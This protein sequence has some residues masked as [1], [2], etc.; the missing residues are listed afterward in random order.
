MASS[1]SCWS[2]P[3]HLTAPLLPFILGLDC[4]A[5]V[6]ARVFTIFSKGTLCEPSDDCSAAPSNS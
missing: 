3:A 2:T 6:N 4:K 5:L 1:T